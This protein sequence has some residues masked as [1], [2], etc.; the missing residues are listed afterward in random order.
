MM[1]VCPLV[2]IQYRVQRNRASSFVRLG[3]F[4]IGSVRICKP[5]CA[6]LPGQT[7]WIAAQP[8]VCRSGH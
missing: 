5:V 6:G 4:E 3:R 2:S 7:F 8:L 1:L